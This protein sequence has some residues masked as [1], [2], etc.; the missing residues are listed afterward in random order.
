MVGW[1]V[2]IVW[3]VAAVA[4]LPFT[5]ALVMTEARSRR[6]AKVEDRVRRSTQKRVLYP[7]TYGHM[8]DE[9]IRADAEV[10][11]SDDIDEPWC[12]FVGFVM[13]VTW[14]V[15]LVVWWAYL[16]A[17]DMIGGGDG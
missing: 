9:E 4:A 15:S 5:I 11:E 1:V 14:P 8:T 12:V 16:R 2:G 3:V 17:V 7:Y 10:W 6:V 13:A